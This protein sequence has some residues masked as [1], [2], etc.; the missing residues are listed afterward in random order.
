MGSAAYPR[1]AHPPEGVSCVKAADWPGF[2]SPLRVIPN[3]KFDGEHGSRRE[4]FM[5]MLLMTS[6]DPF[7][8]VTVTIL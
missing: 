2:A 8:T 1:S 6:S 3:Q 5:N 7:S 4:K